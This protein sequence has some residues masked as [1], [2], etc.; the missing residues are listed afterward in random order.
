MSYDPKAGTGYGP[1]QCR[2]QVS[3]FLF[4]LSETNHKYLSHGRLYSKALS[5]HRHFRQK[6]FDCVVPK[7]KKK[8]TRNGKRTKMKSENPN[9]SSCTRTLFDFFIFTFSLLLFFVFES[10]YTVEAVVSFFFSEF[11][12][13]ICSLRSRL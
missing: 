8:G 10:F 3:T 6:G 5:F 1:K 13:C 2:S 4:S 7:K 12:P 11:Q 9:I